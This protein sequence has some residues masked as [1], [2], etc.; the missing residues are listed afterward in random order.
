MR[1]DPEANWIIGRAMVFK[2]EGSIIDPTEGH[3]VTRCYLIEA[4]G[5]GANTYAPGDIVIAHKIFDV[6]LKGGHANRVVFQATEV[7]CRV[8]G[9]ALD[10]FVDLQGNPIEEQEAAA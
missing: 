7:I 8:R 5:S 4:V 3:G 10:Q 6:I 1:L 2:R 9:A